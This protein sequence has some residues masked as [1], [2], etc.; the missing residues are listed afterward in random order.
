MRQLPTAQRISPAK[1][2]FRAYAVAEVETDQEIVNDD[3]SGDEVIALPSDTWRSLAG[4][5][6]GELQIIAEQG[7]REAAAA[8]LTVRGLEWSWAT[9]APR[10]PRS[11]RP[12]QRAPRPPP[13][14]GMGE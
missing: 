8:W 1:E 14:C 12:R 6:A 3:A 10:L 4:P 5:R 13:M 2:L 7:G 9:P 11:P